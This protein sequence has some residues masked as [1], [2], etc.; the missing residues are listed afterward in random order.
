MKARTIPRSRV[1]PRAGPGL[2]RH[3]RGIPTYSLIEPSQPKSE[4]EG[5]SSFPDSGHYN[6]MEYKPTMQIGREWDKPRPIFFTDQER[7]RSS[8]GEQATLRD[9]FPLLVA[10]WVFRAEYVYRVQPD[11]YYVRA[12]L[13]G[14][15]CRGEVTPTG[16]S[17][18]RLKIVI[19]HVYIDSVAWRSFLAP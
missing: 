19:P 13:R 11:E 10:L 15:G 2:V 3:F 4:T 14:C 7:L 8:C 5:R 1:R 12:R 17:L 16:I 18:G 9:T 6:Q